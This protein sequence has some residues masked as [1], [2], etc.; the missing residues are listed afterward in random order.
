MNAELLLHY[1][2]ILLIFSSLFFAFFLLSLNSKNRLANIFLAIF[3]IIRTIDILPSTFSKINL[4]PVL[5]ILRMDIGAYFQAP[6]LF[7]FMLSV[8]YHDFKLSTR[9]LT[10]FLP[11]LI[12]SV[13]LIPNFYLASPSDRFSFY[14]NYT[15]TFEGKISYVLATLQNLLYIIV[16][17][18]VLSK[19]RKLLYENYSKSTETNYR[20]LFQMNVIC[21]ILFI[22]AMAK[23][24]Y[25]FGDHYGLISFLRFSTSLVMLAFTY[26]LIYKA[27]NAPDLFRGISSKLKLA[28]TLQKKN[29]KPEEVDLIKQKSKLEKFMTENEPYLDSELTIRKLAKQMQMEERDLSVLINRDLKMNFYEL[30]N[31]Y[32]IDKAK[33]LLKDAS[34]SKLT[35]SEILYEVGYNSKSSFNS[36]FK[37]IT[38]VAPSTYRKKS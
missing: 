18:V 22:F 1:T 36:A 9:H 17:F 38:G 8:I 14:N 5:D 21:L 33:Q 31:T 26:W 12:G 23:N 20:W 16:T 3:L 34:L 2:N 6:L 27:L 15:Q 35:I 29:N 10:L 32:R 11:F 37:K 19:Y 25:R 28:S 7:L 4:I 30:I 24:I 13:L